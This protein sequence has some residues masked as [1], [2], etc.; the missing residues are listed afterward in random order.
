MHATNAPNAKPSANSVSRV[1]KMIISKVTTFPKSLCLKIQT[2]S[3]KNKSIRVDFEF[4]IKILESPKSIGCESCEP[5]KRC[6]GCTACITDS[7]SDWEQC[8]EGCDAC[9]PCLKVYSY[10]NFLRLDLKL[11]FSTLDLKI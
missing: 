5:C 4:Y 6:I 7:C 1:L 11:S 3:C 9:I 10:K 2:F 8:N